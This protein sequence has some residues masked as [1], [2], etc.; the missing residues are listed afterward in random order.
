MIKAF[1]AEIE[2]YD[3]ITI[4]RHAH[5][6]GDAFGSQYGLKQWIIENY[7]DKQVYALGFDKPMREVFP[8][9]DEASDEIIKNS[10]AIITDTANT[11]RIDDI[12]ALSAKR[13][14]KIDHHPLVDDYGDLKIVNSKAAAACEIVALL[15]D[16]AKDKV[17]SK[18]VA[19]LL[20][21]GLLT[22]SLNFTTSNT[23]ADTLRSASLLAAKGIDIPGINREMFDKSLAEFEI[24]NAIRA[25]AVREDGIYYLILDKNSLLSIGCPAKTAKEYVT[26]FGHI[27]EIKLWCIFTENDQGLFD[28]SLRSKE[29]AVNE[30]AAMYNGGGHKNAAGVKNLS[31]QQVHEIIKTLKGLV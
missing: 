30:V 1:I 29:A 5:P 26:E 2:K 16:E 4:F 19:K 23:T 21:R 28:G 10:L 20:Y 11:E 27:K 9:P 31:L 17:F 25:K 3:I 14:I 22:D 18:E 6:D 15:L 12:R 24:A 13:I 8:V 7:P